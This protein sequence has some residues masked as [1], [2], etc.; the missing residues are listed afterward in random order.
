MNLNRLG[1]Y[2]SRNAKAAGN[3]GISAAANMGLAESSL[4]IPVD[5]GISYLVGG[6]FRRAP[7]RAARSRDPR[8]GGEEHRQRVNTSVR[9]DGTRDGCVLVCY[10]VAL[11]N[12]RL[13][14]PVN[15]CD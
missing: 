10:S 15:S 13:L 8:N 1:P 4:D 3:T 11:C 9:T 12:R 14:R 5:N 7:V 6:L 2:D